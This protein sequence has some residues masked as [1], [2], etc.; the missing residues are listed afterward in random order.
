MPMC[1][2]AGT[3]PRPFAVGVLALLVTAE[4]AARRAG[5]LDVAMDAYKFGYFLIDTVEAGRDGEGYL[6]AE[7]LAARTGADALVARGPVDLER[8]ADIADRHRLLVRA[9]G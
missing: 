6:V 5:R 2:A 8:L 9:S 4:G 1:G 7:M 3:W